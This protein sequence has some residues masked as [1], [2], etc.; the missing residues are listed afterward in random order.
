MRGMR[1]P[2][3]AN[4]TATADA[5]AARI[6]PSPEPRAGALKAGYCGGRRAAGRVG[7]GMNDAPA[8]AVLPGAPLRTSTRSCI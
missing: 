4:R 5:I 8:A 6:P 3:G 1:G 2:T 7:C